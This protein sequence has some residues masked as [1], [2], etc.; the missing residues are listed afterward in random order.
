MNYILSGSNLVS[1]RLIVCTISYL[2][3]HILR[4]PISLTTSVVLSP[5]R[6]NTGIMAIM[7]KW[8]GMVMR[9][10]TINW[11]HPPDIDQDTNILIMSG[12]SATLRRR[13][14]FQLLRENGMDPV[15]V[16]VAPAS[17]L[18]HPTRVLFDF[19]FSKPHK[20]E[21]DRQA[22]LS[23]ID[24]FNRAIQEACRREEGN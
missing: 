8:P 12:S 16:N 19:N 5:N 1:M 4:P 24:T 11:S 20:V 13:K 21:T 23:F 18:N 14:F 3:G 2:V 9:H 7:A 15:I 6:T 10:P 17:C 22:A